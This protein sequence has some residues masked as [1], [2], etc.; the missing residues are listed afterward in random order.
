MYAY[1]DGVGISIHVILIIT[2]EFVKNLSWMIFLC[3]ICTRTD[4]VLLSKMN[5]NTIITIRSLFEQTI[6]T[7]V[8]I[9]HWIKLIYATL[10]FRGDLWIVLNLKYYFWNTREL[11]AC[12]CILFDYLYRCAGRLFT[13]T[14]LVEAVFL[15]FLYIWTLKFEEIINY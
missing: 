7:Y 10:S 5:Q 11:T 13:E 15:H 1:I 14:W 6:I 2:Q 3:C 8:M 4:C 12:V 9:K